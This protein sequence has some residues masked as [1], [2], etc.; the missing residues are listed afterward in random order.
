[1]ILKGTHN[2][3]SYLP[4]EKWWQW[5]LRPF[6]QCQ[7]KTLNEQVKS[8]MQVFDLRIYRDK[9]N[10]W[11]FAHGLVGFKDATFW[12]TVSMLPKG[13]IVRLILE[14]SNSAEDERAFVELCRY[15]EQHH[16]DTFIGGRRKKGWKLLYDFKANAQYDSYIHQ[17][18]GSM[19][20]DARMYER[21]LPW[22]YARR[23]R[24]RGRLP[25]KYGINLYDF[26]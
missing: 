13:A 8:G 9:H 26:V 24:R 20:P 17:W 23:L 4:P 10:V 15:V 14:R 3:M 19:A 12:N 2:S 21:I 18:V 7:R 16:T 25:E 1:M 11:K 6:A 22:A 5:L